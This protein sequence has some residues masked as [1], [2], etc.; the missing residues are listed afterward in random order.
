[1]KFSLN[2]TRKVEKLKLI[3]RMQENSNK[4]FYPFLTRFYFKVIKTFER[5]KRNPYVIST[6]KKKEWKTLKIQFTNHSWFWCC[7]KNNMEQPH[8]SLNLLFWV[9]ENFI[10][11]CSRMVNKYYSTYKNRRIKGTPTGPFGHN[12][13]YCQTIKFTLLNFEYTMI[14]Y[15]VWTG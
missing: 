14:M 7:L 11:K 12:W 15:F 6:E 4:E 13:A 5:H 10:R 9:S 8:N 1:M 3:A 2:W